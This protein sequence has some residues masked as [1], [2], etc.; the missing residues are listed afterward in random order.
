MEF[1]QGTM[2]WARGDYI[3]KM[4]SLNLKYED[5]PE[6]PIGPDGTIAHAFERSLFL[7][8]PSFGRDIVRLFLDEADREKCIRKCFDWLQQTSNNMNEKGSKTVGF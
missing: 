2:F 8:D 7:W 5:F 3:G 1:S 4:L 6:E